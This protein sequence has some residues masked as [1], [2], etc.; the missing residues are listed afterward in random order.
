VSLQQDYFSRHFCGGSIISSWW[1][2]TAAHCVVSY[3][4]PDWI[5]AGAYN[6][7]NSTEPSRQKIQVAEIH[8]NPDYDDGA[9]LR[10]IALIKLESELDFGEEVS[11]VCIPREESGDDLVGEKFAIT[12]WGTTEKRPAPSSDVNEITSETDNEVLDDIEV[13]DDNDVLGDSYDDRYELTPD[14]LMEARVPIVSKQQC[15]QWLVARKE[16]ETTLY[17][18]CAGY[19]EGGTDSC[20][21]DSGGPMV[22]DISGTQQYE[23]IGITSWGL[24]CADVRSPGVYARV[25]AELK[26]IKE[27]TWGDYH[28]AAGPEGTT[29][30]PSPPTVGTVGPSP[31]PPTGGL[32]P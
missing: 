27:T 24:G 18:I 1:I 31:P 11:P 21:G 32:R 9:T 10:D 16:R 26:F 22:A 3:P 29:S 14:P 25:A 23:Q 28:V 17:E 15:D 6:L 8:V 30:P 4:K 7:N 13:L 2:M 5:V 19:E 12:G 20:Q